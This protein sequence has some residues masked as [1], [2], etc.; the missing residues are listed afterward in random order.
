MKLC[1]IF[2]LHRSSFFAKLKV[3]YGKAQGFAETL[4]HFFLYFTRILI[5]NM[6][7]A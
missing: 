4:T 1:A 3:Q 5:A 7:T 6:G 2:M